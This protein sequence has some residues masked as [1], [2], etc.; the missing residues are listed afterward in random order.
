MTSDEVLAQAFDLLQCEGRVSDRALK[1]RFN[2][3][4]DHLEHRKA[5]IVPGPTPMEPTVAARRY[6]ML[7]DVTSAGHG[8]A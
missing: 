2:L 3:N 1:R 8:Q 4:S 6:A 5:A 7:E